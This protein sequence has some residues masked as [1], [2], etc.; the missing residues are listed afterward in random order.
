MKTFILLL[1]T[2]LPT[3]VLA[4]TVL[5]G[6]IS[7]GISYSHTQSG[8]NQSTSRAAISDHDSHIGIRG[9]IPIGGGSQVIWQT[10]QS[11]PV[12]RSTST[13]DSIRNKKENSVFQSLSQE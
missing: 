1:A 2:L 3:V 8:F 6:N 9:A 13:R 11:A 7:S 4:E 10:E 5:Y 12:V